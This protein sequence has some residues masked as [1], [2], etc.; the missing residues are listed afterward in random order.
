MSPDKPSQQLWPNLLGIVI[1]ILFIAAFF[2]PFHVSHHK[3]KSGKVAPPIES[4]NSAAKAEPNAAYGWRL[5]DQIKG[6]VYTEPSGNL[7][8]MELHKDP[9]E[10]GFKKIYV[11]AT[12]E[13]V[14]AYIA[15]SGNDESKY[16]EQKRTLL[17]TFA[18]EYG[19]I[20]VEWDSIYKFRN[21]KRQVS[22]MAIDKFK[23]LSVMYVD[24][25]TKE[26]VDEQRKRTGKT[27]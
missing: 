12:K 4:T 22:L 10:V 19:Q 8:V 17:K 3:E 9:N 16:D 5:E 2:I 6:N 23:S 13:G 20:K 24:V 21:S 26:L 1:G 15:A 14:I 25:P 18:D 27:Y 7:S 11:V